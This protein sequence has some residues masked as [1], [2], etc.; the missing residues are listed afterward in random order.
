MAG[1]AAGAMGDILEVLAA[2]LRDFRAAPH[3]GLF[4]GGVYTLGGWLLILLLLRF[5]LPYLV[6]PLAAGFALIAPFVTRPNETVP[7]REKLGIAP[8]TAA[9]TGVYALRKA[10]GSGEGTI[11][12]QGSDVVHEA[13]VHVTGR[14]KTLTIVLGEDD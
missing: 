1:G 9:R 12:L 5:D 13:R 10:R 8:V 11:V 4:I 14:E 3:F 6:Y 2:G 7:D